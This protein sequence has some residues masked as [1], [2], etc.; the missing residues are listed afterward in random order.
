MS[1]ELIAIGALGAT[2]LLA[3]VTMAYSYGQL[4]SKVKTGL[5]KI[6]GLALKFDAMQQRDEDRDKDMNTRIAHLEGAAGD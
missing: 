4:T 2:L 6:D 1:P 3:I 5:L